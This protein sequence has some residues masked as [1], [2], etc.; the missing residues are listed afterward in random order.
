M[1]KDIARLFLCQ[2]KS[3]Y[4][5]VTSDLSELSHISERIKAGIN[6]DY[7]VSLFNSISSHGS[8]SINLLSATII[9]I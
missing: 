1:H 5:S 6:N 2:F 4:S 7:I 3:L 9:A 8:V